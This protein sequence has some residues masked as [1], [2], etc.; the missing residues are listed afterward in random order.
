MRIIT[1]K[2]K[3][4]FRVQEEIEVL[5][6]YIAGSSGEKTDLEQHIENYKR[7]LEEVNL[8]INAWKEKIQKLQGLI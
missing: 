6:G 3:T 5:R 7:R 4:Q 2:Q 1:D 8:R